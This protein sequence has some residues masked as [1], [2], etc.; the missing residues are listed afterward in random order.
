M[1]ERH[2]PPPLVRIQPGGEPDP[3]AGPLIEHIKAHLANE[4]VEYWEGSLEEFK[5]HI[6]DRLQELDRRE[7]TLPATILT[8]LAEVV[9]LVEQADVPRTGP[10]NALLAD[11]L[12]VAPIRLKLAGFTPKEPAQLVRAVACRG[13]CIVFWGDQSEDWLNE[14]LALNAL[15]PILGKECVCVLLP[16]RE[17]AD[18]RTFRTS[19]ALVIHEASPDGESE[20]RSFLGVRE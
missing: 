18:K 2:K 17:T 6:Y 16:S 15:A 4:G 1:K 12:N 8:R 7:T 13:R 19:K 14:V 11:R 5:T 10:L 9:V 3:A 20:L